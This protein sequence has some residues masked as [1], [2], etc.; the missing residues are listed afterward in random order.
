MKCKIASMLPALFVAGLLTGGC[1][2][3]PAAPTPAGQESLEFM[4]VSP[5]DQEEFQLVAD[6][7]QSR[8]D[9]YYALKTLETYY[10]RNGNLDK[11]QWARRELKNLQKVQT[12][13]W[14][15]LPE[16][17][18]PEGQDINDADERLLV[19][20][21]VTARNE[22]RRNLDQVEDFYQETGQQFR[23]EVVRNMQAR[24]DPVRT[25]MYFLEA[26]IPGRDLTPRKVIPEAERLYEKARQQYKEGKGALRTFVTTDYQKMRQ[27]LGTFR[28]LVQKYPQSTRIAE[29]AYYIGEIYKEYFKENIRAVHWYARAYQWDPDIQLPARFQAATVWDI[30]LHHHSKAIE[31]YQAAIRHEDFKPTNVWWAKRRIRQLRQARQ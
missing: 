30:R 27:A 24:F 17:A 15:G 19:E 31:L 28:E 12:F 2:V 23:L 3:P 14:Q 13:Q 29:A 1:D 20:D 18:L 5:E 21:V 6:L 26:E 8:L 25:Y 4:Q 10:E 22:F 7:E 9:Y 11:L 16:P